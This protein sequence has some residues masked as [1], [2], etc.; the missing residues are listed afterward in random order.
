M[1]SVQ[2]M[3]ESIHLWDL[4]QHVQLSNQADKIEWKWTSN[5]EY[6]AKSA[7]LEGAHIQGILLHM[8]NVVLNRH[9]QGILLHI[10]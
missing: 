3:A 6:S 9:I 8:E 10:Q 2:Q 4:V 5:G 7:Y 1:E